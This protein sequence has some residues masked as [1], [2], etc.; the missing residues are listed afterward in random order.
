ML[1]EFGKCMKHAENDV[2]D[3][4]ASGTIRARGFKSS[5]PISNISIKIDIEFDFFFLQV[6]DLLG[7]E[8][9]SKAL[10]FIH[11][12]SSTLEYLAHIYFNCLSIR[13]NGAS[14]RQTCKTDIT[15][16][17]TLVYW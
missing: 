11:I 17:Y 1:Y 5:C 13:G 10:I 14:Y 15:R 7:L 9:E 4:S 6:Y 12:F 8:M 2:S 3:V 16:I